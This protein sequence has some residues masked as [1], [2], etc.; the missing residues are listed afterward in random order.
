MSQPGQPV[1]IEQRGSTLWIEIDRQERRNALNREVL[2]AIGDG[3]DV[4]DAD[5]ALRSVVLT[6]AGDRA[7][8]AG[9]DLAAGNSTFTSGVDETTTDFGRLARRLS[10]F[11][12]PIIG[13]I[14]G[15]CV[16]GGMS[17]LGICDLVVASDH[18]RFGLPEV[19]VGVYPM[20]VLVY[21]RRTIAPIHFNELSLLGDLIDA[22]R[23]LEMG[24]VN[25]VVP[26]DELD[27]AV[28]SLAARIEKGSPNVIRRG[29]YAMNAMESMS[30][31]AALAFAETQITVASRTPDA[32]EGIA[33]FN[34]RRLPFWDTSERTAR[35]D[36]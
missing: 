3:I 15:A 24:L 35:A 36:D 20:Q 33:A 17:L 26:F 32:A 31:E 13:R 2:D 28:T 4:A 1:R 19:R 29:K 11:G 16:A 27:D 34:E 10:T 8:C 18:A 5:D 9:A 23:A 12:K 6:G 30:F 14:N 25:R 7:F 22:R 21:L